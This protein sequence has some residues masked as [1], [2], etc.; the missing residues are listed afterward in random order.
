MDESDKR[1]DKA[2][3]IVL[4][5]ALILLPVISILLHLK[6]P[7]NKLLNIL[8]N[9]FTLLPLSFLFSALS[10]VIAGEK[11]FSLPFLSIIFITVLGS[12]LCT[13]FGWKSTIIILAIYALFSIVG[14]FISR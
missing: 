12:L 10:C 3:K 1:F 6:F 14:G 7:D 4:F 13:W 11:S 8:A 5:T 9:M 2:V